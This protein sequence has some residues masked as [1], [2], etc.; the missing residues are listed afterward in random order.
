MVILNGDCRGLQIGAKEELLTNVY[1][2]LVL[3]DE[4]CSRFVA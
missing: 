3:Q 2:V 4:K 1:R